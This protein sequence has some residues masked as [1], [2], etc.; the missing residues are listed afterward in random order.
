MQFCNVS[1]VKVAI[2]VPSKILLLRENHILKNREIHIHFNDRVK[3]E[4]DSVKQKYDRVNDRVLN[5]IK[6]QHKIKATEIS[7]R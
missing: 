2:A 7:E 6:Q 1:L 4:N 5:L 3:S